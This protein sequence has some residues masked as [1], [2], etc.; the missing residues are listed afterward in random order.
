MRNPY[1]TR[2]LYDVPRGHNPERSERDD[3]RLLLDE[4]PDGDRVL[5]FGE[6]EEWLDPEDILPSTRTRRQPPREKPY[7]FSAAMARDAEAFVKYHAARRQK[8]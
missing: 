8:K 1:G 7:D 2:Y 3:E 5:R 6:T 4:S